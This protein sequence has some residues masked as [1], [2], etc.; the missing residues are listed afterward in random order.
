MLDFSWPNLMLLL[1]CL[2]FL[3]AAS[4]VTMTYITLFYY[5]ELQ[6]SKDTVGIIQSIMPLVSLFSIPIQMYL[7]EINNWAIKRSLMGISLI[8]LLIWSLNLITIELD[9]NFLIPF[10]IVISVGTACSLSSGGSLLDSLTFL[11]LDD[12]ELYGQQRL[13]A[14]LSWGLSSLF[15]GFMIDLTGDMN[16]QFYIFWLCLGPFI[17]LLSTVNLNEDEKDNIFSSSGIDVDSIGPIPIHS[18]NQTLTDETHSLL[19]HE[20]Q[21]EDSR[22]LKE[23]AKP[24]TIAFFSTVVLLGLVFNVIQ[25]YLFIYLTNTW[26]A[27]TL[28]CGL[29]T[30][31]S[32]AFELP[33]F[34][35]SD[36]VMKAM[37]KR[38]M[39]L[40]AHFL[41]LVRLFLY[42]A[43]PLI[44]GILDYPIVML[45]VELLHGAAFALQWSAGM[46]HTQSISPKGFESTFVGIYCSLYNNAGGIVGN[47][48]GGYLYERFGHV[49]LWLGCFVLVFFSMVLLFA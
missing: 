2:Y 46:K 40:A 42:V 41:L 20:V 39:I 16:F 22:L 32:I 7:L 28:L 6:L 9:R 10:L 13:Y 12:P 44:P 24:K 45:P 43:L 36:K 49:V 8:G 25:T 35:Y 29:T 33:L 19:P 37:G 27:S 30:P 11:L 26:K 4:S 23:I 18:S 17:M 14:S 21:K 47:I 1:K 31:F 48:I 38:N 15:T 34:Y 5:Q 3:Q